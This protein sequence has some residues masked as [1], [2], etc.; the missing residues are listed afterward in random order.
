MPAAK[1]KTDFPRDAFKPMRQYAEWCVDSYA[2]YAKHNYLVLGDCIE[3]AT[4]QAK[5]SFTA[6]DP[7]VLF[8]EHTAKGRKFAELMGERGNTFVEMTRQL[9]QEAQEKMV[10]F[11]FDLKPA[12]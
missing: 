3:Y 8:E 9:Q 2:K 11:K 5:A 1:D 7:S 12:V 4:E 10:D 6:P